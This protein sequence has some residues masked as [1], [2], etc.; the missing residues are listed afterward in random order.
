MTS[1]LTVNLINRDETQTG[2]EGGIG[3]G[4]GGQSGPESD[5]FSSFA[6]KVPSSD[7][8]KSEGE[9]KKK[10]GKQWRRYYVC[11]LRVNFVNV[12]NTAGKHSRCHPRL[13]LISGVKRGEM[14]GAT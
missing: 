9:W 13:S 6:A 11:A 8:D 10:R 7:G 3:G 14:G 12:E 4:R 5:C 2:R 1:G